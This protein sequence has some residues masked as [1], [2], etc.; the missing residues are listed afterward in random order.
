MINFKTTV[1]DSMAP[2]SI[3]D[4]QIPS[5]DSIFKLYTQEEYNQFGLDKEDRSL[6]GEL[7]S[8]RNDP[9]I[10]LLRCLSWNENATCV[11][12]HRL[13]EGFKDFYGLFSCEVRYINS[14]K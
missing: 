10:T 9:S 3:R 12:L 14:K 8:L 2:S 13:K 4:R 7:E 1:K 6:I 5:I 11:P